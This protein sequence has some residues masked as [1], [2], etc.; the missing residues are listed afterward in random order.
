MI[1]DPYSPVGPGQLTAVV[2]AMVDPVA[3]I[4]GDDRLV[5]ANRAAAELFAC[6]R[7]QTPG[8]P[9]ADVVPADQWT[10]LR[11]A[12]ARCRAG[13]PVEMVEVEVPAAAGAPTPTRALELSFS[14]L[15]G[16][17]G[18]GGD[19]VLMV[20]R[21]L[22]GI[23]RRHA[24]P[25]GQALQAGEARRVESLATF[26]RG[27][28]HD[29][30]NLLAVIQGSA[31]QLDAVGAARG[32]ERQAARRIIAAGAR[33]AELARQLLVIG[34]TPTPQLERLDLRLLLP[35]WVHDFERQGGDRITVRVTLAAQPV[36]V[37]ADPGML[38]EALA[39]ILA[40]CAD[41]MPEGGEVVVAL[42]TVHQGERA[43]WEPGPYARLAVT[44]T[45]GGMSADVAA[46]AVEPMFTTKP[47]ARGTGM[48]LAVAR[49]MV[50]GMNGHIAIESVVGEGTTVCVLLP[51]VPPFERSC[52]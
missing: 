52:G 10:V 46:R 7:E 50:A 38:E 47:R 12:L 17:G 5:E 22:T 23:R 51:L 34:H 16:G 29:L 41:A 37:L 44:D 3:V 25:V 33:V 24:G 4:D 43:G 9:V 15:A 1:T 32:A 6:S 45:G 28:A 49:A 13:E 27:L 8:I 2:Q 31:E 36:V 20:G 18:P 19:V 26:A 42:T 30:N 11:P 35:D 40:N 21:D 14:L 39:A 48:G